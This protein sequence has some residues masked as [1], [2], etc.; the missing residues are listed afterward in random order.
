MKTKLL[1][2]LLFVVG[3]CSGQATK[4]GLRMN[5]SIGAF[6]AG[7]PSD[8]TGPVGVVGTTGFTVDSVQVGDV[9]IDD[10]HNR[11]EVAGITIIV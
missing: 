1:I 3:I 4:D 11:Y 8:F 7:G 6:S 10:L 2:L 5:I 9:L